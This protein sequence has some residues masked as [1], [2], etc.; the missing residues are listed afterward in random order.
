[1]QRTHKRRTVRSHR[2]TRRSDE[3]LTLVEVIV[4]ISLL[5]IFAITFAPILYTNLDITARQATVAYAAQRAASYIDDA[6][7]AAAGSC[8]GLGNPPPV[9]AP[10]QDRR[11][12]WVKVSSTVDG[13]ATTPTVPT[14][15]TLTVTACEATGEDDTAACTAGDRKLTVVSTKIMVQGA[16]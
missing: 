1:M 4:S 6:R 15:V 5:G 8:D 7:E 10:K 9:S 11:D 13:C 16:P 3:G 2:R 12:V 14:A